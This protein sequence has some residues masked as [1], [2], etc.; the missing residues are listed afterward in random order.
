MTFGYNYT[1]LA[2]ELLKT[3]AEIYPNDYEDKS[4]KSMF[5][6]IYEKLIQKGVFFP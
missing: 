3:M 1:L 2:C 4:E 5:K 6:I